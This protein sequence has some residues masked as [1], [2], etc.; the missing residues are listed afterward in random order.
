MEV[1]EGEL[2]T[3]DRDRDRDRDSGGSVY[4]A[5]LNEVAL[6]SPLDLAWASTDGW[7]GIRDSGRAFWPV[8]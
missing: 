7:L 3:S 6:W 8:V 2:V 1:L 5:K 4:L